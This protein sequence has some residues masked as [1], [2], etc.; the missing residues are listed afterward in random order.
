MLILVNRTSKKTEN[1]PCGVKDYHHE[2]RF[3]FALEDDSTNEPLLVH[4][5]EKVVCLSMYLTKRGNN[6]LLQFAELVGLS[7]DN[8]AVEDDISSVLAERLGKVIGNLEAVH[9]SSGELEAKTPVL[10]FTV[11]CWLNSGEREESEM[12]YCLR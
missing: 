8:L 7:P 6:P 12:V 2:F 9:N 1:C 10:D 4:V 11:Q 5:D 3:Y